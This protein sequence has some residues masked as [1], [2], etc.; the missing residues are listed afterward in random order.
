MKNPES[1]PRIIAA[2]S[3]S[4][5]MLATVLVLSSVGC[6]SFQ[7][8]HLR[9]ERERVNRIVAV[10]DNIFVAQ[11]KLRANGFQLVHENP[12]KPTRHQN[13]MMQWV[14]I[15]NPT[16]DDLMFETITGGANPFRSESFYIVIRAKVDGTIYEIE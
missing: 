16:G 3:L 9:K 6:A 4:R 14:K 15:G 2:C 5:V 11:K 10:G 1:Y 8:V 12:T 7:T 13:H